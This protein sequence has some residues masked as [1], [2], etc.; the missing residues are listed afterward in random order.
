MLSSLKIKSET[1]DGAPPWSDLAEILQC[2]L[3]RLLRQ[4]FVSPGTTRGERASLRLACV[5]SHR[6]RRPGLAQAFPRLRTPQAIPRVVAREPP[7][8][9]RPPRHADDRARG[10]PG[11]GP[12]G[13][14][15][16]GLRLTALAMRDPSIEIVVEAAV[17]E[18]AIGARY[19]RFVLELHGISLHEQRG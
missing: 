4:R 16:P 14:K 2:G 13:R 15:E 3:L 6:E 9:R 12:K 8:C 5:P 19:A 17:R 10:A 11:R 7:G 18:T 1:D